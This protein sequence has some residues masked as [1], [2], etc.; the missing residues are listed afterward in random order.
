MIAYLFGG[1]RVIPYIMVHARPISL[2]FRHE[3]QLVRRQLIVPEISGQPAPLEQTRD[4][5]SIFALSAPT[6]SP[7]EKKFNYY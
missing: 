5:Q 2:V 4:F 3:E 1:K 6:V 7:I